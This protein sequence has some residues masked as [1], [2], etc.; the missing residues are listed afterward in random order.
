MVVVILALLH[1]NANF[2]IGGQQSP[3][4]H[5][6]LYAEPVAHQD[7]F[8]FYEI[9][10]NGTHVVKTPYTWQQPGTQLLTLPL[11][12]YMYIREH[13]YGA[14]DDYIENW[15]RMH[16][17]IASLFNGLPFFPGK[18]A[19]DAFPAWLI[20][21]VE[22]FEKVKVADLTILKTTVQFNNDGSIQLL[23]KT[24]ACKLK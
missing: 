24:A 4:F 21:K 8:S 14:M 12:Q 7:S 10:Y 19:M 22:Q 15:N 23:S 20:R 13:G 16:P 11:K 9:Q 18:E 5:W 17:A 2:L 6:N 3:F 1:L